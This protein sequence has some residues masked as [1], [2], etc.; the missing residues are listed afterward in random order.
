[1]NTEE[2]LLLHHLMSQQKEKEAITQ[3]PKL[4][5]GLDYYIERG[6]YVFTEHYLTKRGYCC[7]NGCRHCPYKACA[8]PKSNKNTSLSP[9]NQ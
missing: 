2:I 8:M 9:D 4:V 5:A 7:E 6:F 3:K 1:M